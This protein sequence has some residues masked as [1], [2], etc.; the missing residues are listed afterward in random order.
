MMTSSRLREV[1]VLLLSYLATTF[2]VQ[3]LADTK[4]LL[5][6]SKVTRFELLVECVLLVLGGC[7]VQ[8]SYVAAK[9]RSQATVRLVLFELAL[10]PLF[11]ICYA[12]MKAVFLNNE[13]GVLVQAQSSLLW[14]YLEVVLSL[15]STLLAVYYATLQRT[16]DAT[17]EF[18]RDQGFR[19]VSAAAK[20]QQEVEGAACAAATNTRC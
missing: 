9:T 16:E 14:I 7:L 20:C 15:F 17:E 11:E 13:R 6:T 8:R 12:D 4:C 18:F 10:G 2:A 1:R 19:A 5:F 3:A